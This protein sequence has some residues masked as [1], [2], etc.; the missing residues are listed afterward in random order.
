MTRS[1]KEVLSNKKGIADALGL[2]MIGMAMLVA[3][4]VVVGNYAILSKQAS[5]LQT[6]TQQ[7]SNRAELYAGSLNTDLASPQIPMM[8]RQCT[9]TPAMCTVILSATPSADGSKTVLRVQGD[10]VSGVG[11]SVTKDVTLVSKEVTHVTGVDQNGDNIWALSSE[12]LHYR[13]WGVASG[14]PT[15]VDPSAMSGPK[16][17]VAW[18]SIADRAGI[19]STGAL[20]T[21]GVNTI[22]QAGT[23]SASTT[24]VAPQKFGGA[25]GF[26]SVVTSDDRGYA[27]DSK[28]DLW[29]WGRND[30]GQL[31]LGNTSAV[32]VPTRI[33][34]SRTMTVAVGKDNTFVL[35][36]DGTLSVVGAS[37]AGLPANSGLA[38]QVI[39]PGTKY[40]AV[41]AST[42]GAVAMIDS[43]G[44]LTVV[45]NAYPFTPLD[46]GI[47]ISVTLGQTTGYAMGTDARVYV[48]G[49][50]ANGQLG[51]GGTTSATTPTQLPGID[52]VA[53]SGG[54]TSAFVIDVSGKLYYFGK[55]PS[56]SV[57]GTDLPQ[58]NVP[59]KLLAESRF[60]GIAANS[61]DT[62]VALLDTAGNLYGMGTTQPGLWPFN[63]LGANDQP[64]RMPFPVGFAPVTW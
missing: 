31:G 27:I 43:T 53:V 41:A 34:G 60:R 63:Y 50:G 49:Q 20:W 36:M 12:G 56:G 37:Q 9:T 23:G 54:K 5:Q 61:T 7:I 13:I 16:A 4:G 15:V 40:R 26:R 38:A 52:V 1:I 51:L 39:T 8:A 55:T 45:G 62:A 57:G 11:Q 30:K 58:V 44:K 42:T 14:D 17:G 24:P 28:G 22:G 48:W 6:L 3:I 19:D 10:A 35:G 21:W 59:T 25:T 33:A 2:V 29:V 18:V 46:G 32:M 64:I 47:F